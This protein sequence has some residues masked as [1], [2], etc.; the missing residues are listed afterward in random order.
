MRGIDTASEREAARRAARAKRFASS[1][2]NDTV[3]RERHAGRTAADKELDE[4][5]RKRAARFGIA[6][7]VRGTNNDRMLLS[8][9][10]D[11]ASVVAPQSDKAK[12]ERAAQAL[13]TEW[14]VSDQPVGVSHVLNT[15]FSQ[16]LTMCCSLLNRTLHQPFVRMSF[17]F[18]LPSTSA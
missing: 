9:N 5:A 6:V 17:M 11:I 1:M 7:L 12:A 14:T 3:I 16:L 4:M 15:S 2:V 18:E 10:A 13:G 8:I